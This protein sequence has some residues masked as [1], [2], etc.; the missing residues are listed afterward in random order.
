MTELFLS[1]GSLP[2]RSNVE[3]HRSVLPVLPAPNRLPVGDILRIAIKEHGSRCTATISPRHLLATPAYRVFSRLSQPAP[4]GLQPR[5]SFL[6]SK[7]R[8]QAGKGE[9]DSQ[10]TTLSST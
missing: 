4:F 2:L 8:I 3:Y 10:G 1:G 5:F 9:D 7:S 6:P